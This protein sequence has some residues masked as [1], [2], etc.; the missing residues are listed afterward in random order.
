ML[1]YADDYL[2]HAK[3]SNARAKAIDELTEAVGSLWTA[4]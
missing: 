3:S 2:L 1:N 4:V